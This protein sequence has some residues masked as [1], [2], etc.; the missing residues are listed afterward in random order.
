[1][2]IIDKISLGI[3]DKKA[4]AI[5]SKEVRANDRAAGYNKNNNGYAPSNIAH[6]FTDI[7]YS[8]GQRYVEA[9]AENIPCASS[10]AQED[11]AKSIAEDAIE[12]ACDAEV[13]AEN[14]IMKADEAISATHTLKA[15]AEEAI[16]KAHEANDAIVGL[17]EKESPTEEV[18]AEKVED[19]NMSAA[20]GTIVRPVQDGNNDPSKIDMSIFGVSID[21][22]ALC[23]PE[24]NHNPAP[25]HQQP[26][27][28]TQFCQPQ[29]QAMPVQNVPQQ[30]CQPQMQYYPNPMMPAPA[31]PAQPVTVV[32][33]GGV[34]NSVVAGPTEPS[35]K[36]KF[37]ERQMNN[38]V[39][40]GFIHPQEPPTPGMGNHK[41]DYPNIQKNKPVKNPPE[42]IESNIPTLVQP[43]QAYPKIDAKDINIVTDVEKTDTT[44]VKKS[45]FDNSMMISKYPFLGTIEQIAVD[46]GYQICFNMKANGTNMIECHVCDQN[47]NEIMVKSFTID[48]GNIIDG[49]KKIFPVITDAYESYTAYALF[50]ASGN[51][52]KNINAELIKSLI[53]GGPQAVTQKPL[54]NQQYIDL[55]KV[56]ALITIPGKRLKKDERKYIQSRL[57][58][59]LVRTDVLKKYVGRTRFR[60]ASFDN[61]TITLISNGVPLNYGG[62]I[63]SADN[64]TIKITKDSVEE[65]V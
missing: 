50:A 6:H 63:L 21:N 51:D 62:H 10:P 38:G 11:D 46:N 55:N 40:S 22:D 37:F 57:M 18:G 56:V 60:V 5:L 43:E 36:S 58:D 61:G 9:K 30:F 41:V 31:V 34:I 48:N 16:Y 42:V 59:V 12:K 7:V 8:N 23:A 29:Q 45:I 4:K 2:S 26:T 35:L 47:S 1:M 20:M 24:Q 28:P 49:R 15:M 53:I 14:A 39:Q 65:I 32:G 54:F 52:T 17:A 27:M 44:I 3:L 19:E 33:P 13:L 25:A 64:V